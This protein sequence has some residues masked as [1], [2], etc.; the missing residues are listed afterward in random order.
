MSTKIET[1]LIGT[2]VTSTATFKNDANAIFAPAIVNLKYKKPDTPGTIVSNA[3]SPDVS[4]KYIAQVLLDTA[5]TWYFRWEAVDTN[6]V[7]EE[8]SI[9][10]TDTKVK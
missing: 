7:A 5:G 3:I 8:F 10:V 6:A 4:N 2:T 1:R 9:L